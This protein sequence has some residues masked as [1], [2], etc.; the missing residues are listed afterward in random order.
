M[1]FYNVNGNVIYSKNKLEGNEELIPNIVDASK[2]KH[3]PNVKINGSN[4]DVVVGSVIH[5]M[6]EKHYIEFILVETTKGFYVRN[7]KAGNEPRAH[8]ELTNEDII[9]VYDYCNLH[10]LWVNKPNI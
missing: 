2:E 7:L 9:A 8:F 5:P 4:V 1:Y 10:G 3:I 6:E